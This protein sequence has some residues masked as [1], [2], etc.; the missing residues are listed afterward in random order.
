MSSASA[1]WLEIG[2]IIKPASS[3]MKNE[4]HHIIALGALSFEANFQRR[5]Y[6]H[7]RGLPELAA[8]IRY[9]YLLML[10]SR[11]QCHYNA[12][13]DSVTHLCV[14]ILWHSDVVW[15]LMKK[16]KDGQHMYMHSQTSHAKKIVYQVVP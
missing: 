12:Y 8:C 3:V 9:L 10:V 5:V 15:W 6:C 7:F 13:V 2:I 1:V 14:G 11:L 16:R 4:T